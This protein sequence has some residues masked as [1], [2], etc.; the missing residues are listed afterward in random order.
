MGPAKL[1][2]STLLEQ[3]RRQSCEMSQKLEGWGK[4]LLKTCNFVKQ[5]FFGMLCV[6]NCLFERVVNICLRTM[7]LPSLFRSISELKLSQ[8]TRFIGIKLT[9]CNSLCRLLHAY[10]TPKMAFYSR[11]E[12]T[13]MPPYLPHNGR[14]GWAFG[15]REYLPFREFLQCSREFHS[16]PPR[17]DIAALK[18]DE[19]CKHCFEFGL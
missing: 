7:S 9:F 10:A 1:P 3:T 18:W 2:K 11:C 14:V 4:K 6:Q 13:L 5:A 19:I 8:F 15:F 12:D 17:P 16:S